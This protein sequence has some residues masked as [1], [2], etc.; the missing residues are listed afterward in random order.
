MRELLDKINEYGLKKTGGTL[1][2]MI[3]NDG[4]GWLIKNVF[5]CNETNPVFEFESLTELYEELE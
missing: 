1:S 3:E 5:D 2:L 4:S